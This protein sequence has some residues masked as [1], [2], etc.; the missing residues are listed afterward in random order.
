MMGPSAEVEIAKMVLQLNN[1]LL[2]TRLTV[3]SSEAQVAEVE[4]ALVLYEDR[5][6]AMSA[7]GT[8][9]VEPAQRTRTIIEVH[10]KLERADKA[11][12]GLSGHMSS[13][14]IV[15]SK[16]LLLVLESQS[17]QAVAAEIEGF[18]PGGYSRKEWEEGWAAIGCGRLSQMHGSEVPVLD[19]LSARESFS[20]GAGDTTVVV[21]GRTGK[22][23]DDCSVGF[24]SQVSG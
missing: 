23:Q 10:T 6:E 12:D 3:I 8:D 16:A 5:I 17:F 22:V 13:E 11:K 20:F 7:G 4:A 1:A 18:M 24:G 9:E 14:T 15:V 2:T 19:W 21:P